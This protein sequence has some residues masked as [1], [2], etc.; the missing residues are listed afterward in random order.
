VSDFRLLVLADMHFNPRVEAVADNPKRRCGLGTELIGRATED[1]RRQGG[2]DAV[3][4]LGDL[5]ADG[6]DGHA[7]H[8]AA[9][10]LETLKSA[11]GDAPVMVLPGNHDS[12]GDR[13][14]PGLD[15]PT[16]LRELGGYRF[17]VFSDQWE[18]AKWGT[19][20]PKDIRF[21]D[22]LASREG[23]PIVA[24]Q[25]SPMNPRILH[26]YP[27]ML[28]NRR[29]VVRQYARAGVVLSI[30]GHYH[31]GQDLN[32]RDG[33]KYVTAPALCERPFDYL[34]VTLRGREVAVERRSLAIGPEIALFD[35]HA[36]TQ[37]AYCGR[38]IDAGLAIA[39]SR[40]FGLSG[41]V[42]VEHAPQLYCSAEDFWAARHVHEP[43]CWRNGEA[44]RMAEFRAAMDSLR[45]DFA[46]VGL[47]VE[48]D[49]EGRLT[50]HEE[51]HAWAD[52]LVGAIH[53]LPEDAAA[54]SDP[55]LARAFLAAN[56]AILAG[57]VDVLAHPFRLFRWAGRP[58]PAELYAPLARML[59]ETGTAAE[60]N[61]HGNTPDPSFF[62][63][64]L[65]AGV[66]LALGTDAHV[67]SEA[68]ALSAHAS[69]LGRIAGGV[70][71]GEV[72]MPWPG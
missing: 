55:E 59:A 47:E 43:E 37:F 36:H 7:D 72:L 60:I 16:R 6:A 48:L 58:V 17:V 30:S 24:L 13:L 56:E 18:S 61:C 52:L 62:A 19:R 25:H 1:A 66:K 39:R 12:D 50:V 49:A 41:V 3:A 57:G 64:C 35:G 34:L 33:V 11:A 42:L 45:G 68:G 46:R 40:E 31:K 54:M 51:D 67:P 10:V 14:P 69:L 26:L 23:G 2:F 15:E 22:E 9:E 5:L 4:V 44:S 63:C 53:W 8:D 27:Y 65:E 21:L 71:L 32:E 28:T 38:E 29:E 20:R 70:E